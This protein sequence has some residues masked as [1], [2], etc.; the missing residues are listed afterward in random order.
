[1]H[2]S[3]DETQTPKRCQILAHPVHGSLLHTVITDTTSIHHTADARRSIPPPGALIQAA[4]RFLPVC[5]SVCL[6]VLFHGRRP[7]TETEASLSL[8]LQY[9]TVCQL[10]CGVMM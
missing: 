1:M 7:A 2:V 10:L 5:L 8:V 9:G 3:R 6:Y 4:L